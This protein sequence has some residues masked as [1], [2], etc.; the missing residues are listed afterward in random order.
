SSGSLEQTSGREQESELGSPKLSRPTLPIRYVDRGEQVTVTVLRDMTPSF[1][2]DPRLSHWLTSARDAAIC[3]LHA[4][5]AC[6][7]SFSAVA[8]LLAGRGTGQSPAI[9]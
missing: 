5:R 9:C 4:G 2:P 8:L 7:G 6:L 1:V 3:Q